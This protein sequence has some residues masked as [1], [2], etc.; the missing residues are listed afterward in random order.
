MIDDDIPDFCLA[1]D[2][3]EECIY[4]ECPCANV[5]YGDYAKELPELMEDVRYGRIKRQPEED[6]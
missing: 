2:L 3:D 5:C 4:P 1:F 6:E